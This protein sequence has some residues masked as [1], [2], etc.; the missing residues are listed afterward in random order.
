[1][2]SRPTSYLVT[3]TIIII[4]SSP[5]AE[6]ARAITIVAAPV[7][8]FNT[9][10]VSHWF[11]DMRVPNFFSIPPKNRPNFY[12]NM[13]SWAHIGL[14]GS[15]SALLVGWLVVAVTITDRGKFSCRF[16]TVSWTVLNMKME[17]EGKMRSAVKVEVD[18]EV[19]MGKQQQQQK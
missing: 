18:V 10:E 1:M 13:F 3:D 5:R 16:V 14:A 15:L 4:L 8:V 17:Q 9:K 11:P 7:N 6:S 2:Y 12:Q 19:V